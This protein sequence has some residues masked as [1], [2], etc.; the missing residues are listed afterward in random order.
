MSR[1]SQAE[2]PINSKTIKTLIIS[3]FTLIIVSLVFM[4]SQKALF[5]FTHKTKLEEKLS[6]DKILTF[7][8]NGYNDKTLN[9]SVF[10]FLQPVQKKCGLF[11]INPI[12]T[13]DD[14]TIEI[15]KGYALL[16]MI[17]KI[18]S[19]TGLKINFYINLNDQSISD[20]VDLFD[21]LPFYLDSY[22]NISSEKYKR[23]TGGYILSGEE[24]LDFNE[25]I[26]RDDPM[27]YVNRLNHQES[28]GLSFYDRIKEKQD[29]RKE[30][31]EVIGK[32]LDTNLNGQ[33]LYYLYTYIKNNNIAF[34]ISEMPGELVAEPNNI[35]LIIHE[36]NAN[37]GFSKLA[38]YLS[39]GDYNIGDLARTEVLNSTE[40]NGLAKSVKSIL[41]ENSIK[42]L[43]VGN[44]WN[45]RENKS[46]IIDRSGSTEYSY[47]IAKLLGIK[48]VYHLI[49]KD[50]G[51]DTTVILGEDFEI[52]P[53][54]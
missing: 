15:M 4:S 34:S 13:F 17:P 1:K 30:W 26:V 5:K 53:G 20:I 43:S 38:A 36:E 45:S 40:T 31:F 44:G 19:I 37:F 10:I 32:K 51:L 48:T 16:Y 41:N 28:I 3:L 18:E 35:K 46:L 29:L 12:A 42:V 9:F 54:K 2:D 21:G 50:F 6:Q 14:K 8:I 25:I 39:S 22:S 23:N 11:F 49:N 24:L 33:D 52:K 7:F 47:R 27:A